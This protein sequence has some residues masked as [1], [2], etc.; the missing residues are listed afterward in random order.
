ML[1]KANEARLENE[2]AEVQRIASLGHVS[3]IRNVNSTLESI[4]GKVVDE[5]KKNGYDVKEIIPNKN[6]IAGI[7]TNSDSLEIKLEEEPQEMSVDLKFNK[8][9]TSKLYVL[10]LNKYYEMTIDEDGVEIS[11]TPT[12]LPEEDETETEENKVIAQVENSTIVNVQLTKNTSESYTLTIIPTEKGE[13]KVILKVKDTEITKMI[14][15]KVTKTPTSIAEWKESGE[16]VKEKTTLSDENEEN[17]VIPAGF[18][19]SPESAD[20]VKEG[21]VVVAPDGSEFVWIPVPNY[22]V[23]FKTYSNVL[24]APFYSFNKDGYNTANVSGYNYGEPM[25][26]TRKNQKGTGDSNQSGLN[27]LRDIL[28]FSGTDED[29]LTEWENKLKNEFNNLAEYIKTSKGFYIGR[30]EMSCRSINLNE[31]NVVIAQSKK[32]VTSSSASDADTYAWYGLYKKAEEYAEKNDLDSVVNSDMLWNC[33]YDQMLMW[34][35][36]NNIEVSSYSVIEGRSQNKTYKTG[37][38]D[39]DQL[40]K[41]YDLMGS[42]WEWT[43]AADISY[44]RSISKTGFGMDTGVVNHYLVCGEVIMDKNFTHI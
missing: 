17:V 23:M 9:N 12:E 6:I 3:G 32:N 19:I 25:V 30:Y 37:S 13:T 8:N 20:T 22:N 40:N 15:I 2:I 27:Y 34:L 33:Q 38:N 18:S 5:L 26:T 1:N 29:V 24:R 7:E 41:V 44:R 10:I 42:R 43:Q 39:Q 4:K 28:G 11:K 14:N 21:I 31:E 36:R 35:Q 16:S